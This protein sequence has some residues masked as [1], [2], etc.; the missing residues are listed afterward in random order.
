[1]LAVHL[2]S[3]SSTFI[4]FNLYQFL[5]NTGTTFEQRLAEVECDIAGTLD[6][7]IIGFSGVNGRASFEYKKNFLVSL[8]QFW[9]LV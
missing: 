2:L 8:W 3:Y 1:M 5:I 4:I 7:R 9:Q 6:G